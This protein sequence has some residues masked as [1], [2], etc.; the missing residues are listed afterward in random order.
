MNAKRK[1]RVAAGSGTKVEEINRLLKMHMQMATMM[2][3]MGQG[4]GMLGKLMGGKGAPDAA[5]LEKMQ[6]ELAALDPN[7][8]PADLKDMMA[9]GTLARNA[10]VAARPAAAAFPASAA[11][12]ASA[13]ATPSGAFRER[14]NDM[15]QRT[16]NREI[17]L[18][19]IAPKVT[20]KRYYEFYRD[21]VTADLLRT[22]H[23]PR[24]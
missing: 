19:A 11:C 12:R 20:S 4:K 3:Q 1:K 2:K 24:A 13:A 21:P 23:E 5:E 6:A 10:E 14:R 22:G 7:A 9:G 17:A 18:P 8:I 16:R 15:T